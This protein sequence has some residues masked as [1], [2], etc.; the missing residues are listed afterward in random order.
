[1]EAKNW[2]KGVEKKLMIAQCTDSEKVLFLVHQLFSTAR[3]TRRNQAIRLLDM[4]RVQVVKDTQAYF[5]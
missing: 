3:L 4:Q 1:M 2:L 5:N